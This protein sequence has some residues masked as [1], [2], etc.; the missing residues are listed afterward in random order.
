MECPGSHAD[1]LLM[2]KSVDVAFVRKNFLNGYQ[3]EMGAGLDI[4]VPSC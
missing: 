1:S 2:P 3:F 4:N